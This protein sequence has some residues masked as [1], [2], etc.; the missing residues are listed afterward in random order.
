MHFQSL[1]NR[2][3]KQKRINDLKE[4]FSEKKYIGLP[5]IFGIKS[6]K[7]GGF[8]IRLTKSNKKSSYHLNVVRRKQWQTL[9]KLN[10]SS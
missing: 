2:F 8:Y 6:I 10:L 1:K 9:K 7:F 5:N 4:F 3:E